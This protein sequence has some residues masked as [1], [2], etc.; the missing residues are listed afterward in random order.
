MRCGQKTAP[1]ISKQAVD[2][3]SREFP[4]YRLTSD[5]TSDQRRLWKILA[6]SASIPPRMMPRRCW[7]V[8]PAGTAPPGWHRSP[9]GRQPAPADQRA[10]D[11]GVE[12]RT[13]RP[14]R[15]RRPGGAARQRHLRG[16]AV[17]HRQGRTRIRGR[18]EGRAHD[19]ARTHPQCRR[20]GVRRPLRRRRRLADCH[21][22]RGRRLGHA[23]RR[24][25]GVGAGGRGVEGARPDGPRRSR[26][27]CRRRCAAGRLGGRLRARR[28]LLAEAHQPHR[29]REL[30]RQ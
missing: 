13:A 22:L 29:R 5:H 24:P 10:G 26:G 11:G 3:S 30:R 19:R 21:L 18:A 4:L 9:L 28:A 2:W 20:A 7:P 1:P 14:H 12:R 8:W 15:R 23:R 27:P 6:G 16:A 17:D 25:A